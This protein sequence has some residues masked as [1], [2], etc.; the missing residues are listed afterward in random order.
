M[1]DPESVIR[2]I[3]DLGSRHLTFD[4]N[5]DYIDVG[6]HIGV[7]YIV[8]NFGLHFETGNTLVCG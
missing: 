1:N 5:M 6:T 2:I 3:H 8:L 7:I 4:A